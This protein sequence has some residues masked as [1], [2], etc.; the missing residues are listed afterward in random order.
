MG[1]G[2]TPRVKIT[3]TLHRADHTGLSELLDQAKADELDG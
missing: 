2:I 1:A 3:E